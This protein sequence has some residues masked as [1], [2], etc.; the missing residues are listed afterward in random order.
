MEAEDGLI[1]TYSDIQDFL[2]CRRRWHWHYV[3]DFGKPDSLIGPLAL[4]SRVH[5][6]QEHYYGTGGDPLAFY[7]ELV[8]EDLERIELDPKTPSWGL[9]QFYKD[10]IVGRNCVEAHL[11]WLEV[12]G[13]DD[14]LEVVD[15]ERV[16]EAPLLGGRVMLRGKVDVLFRDTET[17]F[18]IVNDQ[19]T[20]G[21]R[22]GARERLERSWQHHV[23]LIALRLSEPDEIVH[24]ACYTV[25]QKVA[26]R[27]R[28]K[29]PLVE[30]F[31]VPGTTRTAPNKL[32]QL[33][34]I[35][36]DMLESI[37]RAATEGDAHAY[38][39]PNYECTWCDFRAPCEIADE[40]PVAVR[41]MLDR[42]FVRGGRHSRYAA[43]EE[44][45]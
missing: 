11:E 41:A 3:A 38:P 43:I 36:S 44:A 32:R 2:T 1:I 45:P 21:G 33:E 18:L 39:S 10:V 4:G 42:E 6:A 37:E 29:L 17:G 30:R 12:T 20:A 31:F 5:R 40:S 16:V 35:C 9:D 25:M 19:K 26:R 14:G 22:S 34:A 13:S 15:V 23:Y 8:S 27:S 28:T 7:E 24:K